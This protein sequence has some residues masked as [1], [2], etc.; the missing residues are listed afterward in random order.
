[1]LSNTQETPLKEGYHDK[2]NTD[3]KTHQEWLLTK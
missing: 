2:Y 3:N 1:M